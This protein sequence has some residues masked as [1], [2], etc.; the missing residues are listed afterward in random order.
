MSKKVEAIIKDKTTIV[1]TEDAQKGDYIDLGNLSNV[2]LT[3]LEQQLSNAKDTVYQKKLAEAKSAWQEN[4]NK[5]LALQE[6]KLVSQYKEEL[7][8]LEQKLKTAELEAS[9]KYQE[10]LRAQDAKSSQE[11]QQL[12]LAM[13]ELKNQLANAELTAKTKFQEDLRTQDAKASQEKKQLELAIAELKNQLSNADLKAEN[14][15]KEKLIGLQKEHQKEMDDLHKKYDELNNV[16][17]FLKNQ[18]AAQSNNNLG[19]SLE[20]A[21]DAIVRD[22]LQAGLANCTWEKDTKYKKDESDIKDK[23]SK[24]DYIFKVY[25]TPE[26]LPNE[27]LTSICLEMKD[28]S[29]DSTDRTTNED[30]YNK[31]HKDRNKDN[32]K[33]ALLVSTLSFKNDN[34]PPIYRVLEYPDMYVVQ[35]AY[36][37]T[38]INMIVSL[39]MRFQDLIINSKENELNLS[40]QAEFLDQFESLKNTYLDKPLDG[41]TSRISGI[42]E[43]T[44]KAR[45][46]INNIDK[47]CTEIT[48]QYI[49]AIEAKLDK[50][51]SNMKTNYRKLNK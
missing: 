1:L 45:A 30:H 28:E 49:D 6:A 48:N 10:S 46:S 2:D 29:P 50:F 20:L 33:Y 42:L 40:K 16:Y 34:L 22:A 4:L 17:Q 24:A 25:L 9:N 32:C 15:Y 38:F 44:E 5:E 7:Q 41:L 8:A 18:K 36:M 39:T 43:Q 51:T 13:A 27:L 35:P 23:N 12:E 11:K 3:N 19:A 14:V 47:L 31:L 26:H 37:M 21:C